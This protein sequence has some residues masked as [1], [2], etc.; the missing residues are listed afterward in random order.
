MRQ[1]HPDYAG[2]V[3]NVDWNV[4]RLLTLLKEMKIDKNTIVIFSS[5]HGGLS[6]DGSRK[7]D[8]A[9]TNNPLR[10]GKGHLYEGGLR[11]PLI[12]H[13]NKKIKPGVDTKNIILGMDLFPTLTELV[14]GKKIEGVDGKSYCG[15]LSKKEDWSNRTVYWHEEKARPQSTGDTKCSAIRSGDYKLM[16]FY[17][18]NIVELYNVRKDISEETNLAKS[19]PELTKSLLSQLNDWKKT[20]LVPEKMNMK[21]NARQN[22]RSG[23]SGNP[24]NGKD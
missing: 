18:D 19:E 13:W 17:A 14:L 9:T 3:E 2:M 1:N 5:D 4:G 10:A 12:I 20:Y 24:Q 8:L 7:R 11:V 22:P 15:V 16:H 21:R 23:S 6:N